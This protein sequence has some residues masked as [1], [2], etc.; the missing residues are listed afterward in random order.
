MPFYSPDYFKNPIKLNRPLN[1][2]ERATHM[3][4]TQRQSGFENDVPHYQLS[5]LEH[6]STYMEVVDI[7]HRVRGIATFLGIFA[8][9][10]SSVGLVFSTLYTDLTYLKNA[11][12]EEWAAFLIA[13]LSCGP[14]LIFSIYFFFR[15][16]FAYTHYPVRLNRKNRTVYVWRKKG[17]LAVPWDKLHFWLR[18]YKDMGATV[19]D[20][21]ANV[22]A[23]DGITVVDSFPFGGADGEQLHSRHHF[24][25]FRRY[26][27]ENPRQTYNMLKVCLAVSRRK[28]TW[29]EGYERMVLNSSGGGIIGQLLMCW[30]NIPISITRFIAMRTSKIPQWP[31]WVEQECKIDPKDPYVREA[32][33]LYK[34]K[35]K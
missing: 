2:E 34:D 10:I 26:M 11:N 5:V 32:G 22:L 13:I 31:E 4:Q 33:Y 3:P 20:I 30:W 9:A 21:R 1:D 29:F 23:D 8:I 18:P 6:N 25:Y 16:S 27:E 19:W 17:V 28:E 15:E 24:E 35:K 12:S 7:N 14:L